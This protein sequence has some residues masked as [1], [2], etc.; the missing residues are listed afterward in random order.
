MRQEGVAEHGCSPPGIQEAGRR[1]GGGKYPKN[2]LE[3]QVPWSSVS[4]NQAPA[5]KWAISKFSALCNP[6]TSQ[7]WDWVSRHELW[8]GQ[9]VSKLQVVSKLRFKSVPRGSCD[10][11]GPNSNLHFLAFGGLQ[12]LLKLAKFR[13]HR[14][15]LLIVQLPVYAWISPKWSRPRGKW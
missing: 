1:Q 14:V 9:F 3:G 8:R 5:P 7:Q 11:P 2:T 6:I 4:S 15:M 12:G 10:L 13:K